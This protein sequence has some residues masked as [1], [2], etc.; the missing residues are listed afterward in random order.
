MTRAALSLLVL[1]ATAPLAGAQSVTTLHQGGPPEDRLDVVLVAEGYPAGAEGRFLEHARRVVEALRRKEPFDRYVGLMNVHAVFEA[2]PGQ[3]LEG[4]TR[5]GTRFTGER[6]LTGDL[7]AIQQAA[8]AAPDVDKV[9]VLVD[10]RRHGGSAYGA[11]AIF[12]TAFATT[13]GTLEEVAVHELGHLIGNLADEYTGD[14]GQLS[15]GEVATPERLAELFAANPNVTPWSSRDRLPW[16]EWVDP[17]TRVPGHL[18]TQGVS[19]F[20]GAAYRRD[21]MFRPRRRCCMRDNQAAFCEPCRQ[22]LVLGLARHARPTTLEVDAAAGVLRVRTS[23]PPA[24]LRVTPERRG[25]G[26]V[27]AVEDATPWV[28]GDRGPLGER[29][30]VAGPDGLRVEVAAAP[31]A[32]PAASAATTGLVGHLG[33]DA[34]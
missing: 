19:A 13:G 32:V 11:T 12:T 16:R 18:F 4:A 34:P 25:D 33:G 31:A 26:W 24:D 22:A 6:M 14:P 20:E 29:L 17:H 7:A 28:R 5:F 27:V 8:L 3:G 1:L 2:S 9:L 21:D 10:E 15:S 23:L 30:E